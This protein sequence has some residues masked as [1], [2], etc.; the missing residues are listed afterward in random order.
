MDPRVP[1]EDERKKLQKIYKYHKTSELYMLLLLY[2][3]LFLI[4][5]TYFL[6]QHPLAIFVIVMFSVVMLLTII[7]LIIK[8]QLIKLCPRCST[9]GIPP[10]PLPTNPG[11][12]PK[13]GMY[14]DP[15]YK[16]TK[17]TKKIKL[18]PAARRWIR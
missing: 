2:P 1:N 7:Y 17:E 15:S 18:N 14:L 12:C 13:C 16:E 6:D 9:R 5:L 11:H 8:R 3:T 10:T 4:A